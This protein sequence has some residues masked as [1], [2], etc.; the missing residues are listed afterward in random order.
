M[1][2]LGGWLNGSV[3]RMSEWE[4]WQCTSAARMTRWSTEAFMPG[5]DP[6]K[7]LRT[8]M[9]TVHTHLSETSS[10]MRGAL[11]LSLHVLHHRKRV[12]R[13]IATWAADPP[14]ACEVS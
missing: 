6:L 5:V 11:Q 4:C 1:G 12:C 14:T 3:E 7:H 2:V 9:Q 8:L 13:M 10:T